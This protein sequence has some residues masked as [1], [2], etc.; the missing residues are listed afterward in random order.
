MTAS[1][2]ELGDQSKVIIIVKDISGIIK[3]REEQKARNKELEDFCRAA[4]EREERVREL[5]VE[6]DRL[7]GEIA[8]LKGSYD[9][10][11]E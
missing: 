5:N 1:L 3:D 7:K 10:G 11:Q 8:A 9:H 2:M 4:V 6:I